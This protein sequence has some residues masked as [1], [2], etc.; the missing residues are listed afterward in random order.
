LRESS[1]GG[2]IAEDE[3]AL[4]E[5]ALVFG[6]RRA[7]EVMKPRAEVDYV[8]D[9]DDARA[10]AE[11]AIQTG[12]TRLPVCTADGALETATGVINAKDLLPL[13]LG[14]GSETAPPEELVRPVGHVSESARV[15]ELLR[16]MRD[17]RQHLALVHDEHGT[18]VGLLTMEDIIEELIGEIEDEFDAAPDE[19]S[20]RED[21][22]VFID[23]AA[24]VRQLAQR[25][26]IELGAHHEST[27]GGYLSE[28]LG[29]VPETGETV[30]SLEHE[31]EI[32][33]IDGTRIS[34]V[35]MDEGELGRAKPA[36]AGGGASRVGLLSACLDGR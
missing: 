29:R 30:V 27:L 26:G 23:G 11:R 22:R 31:F 1:Q 7:R 5:A 9:T 2:L 6:D 14:N 35:S 13:V 16:A 32:V 28:Q 17:G 20:R 18:V 10:I 34:E 19:L 36:G 25:L 33:G 24:P 3:S 8:L 21:G 12:R 15:D 4:S